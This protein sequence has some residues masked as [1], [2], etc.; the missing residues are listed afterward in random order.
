[1]FKRDRT[2]KEWREPGQKGR[3]AMAIQFP[4][5]QKAQRGNMNGQKRATWSMAEESAERNLTWGGFHQRWCEGVPLTAKTEYGFPWDQENTKKT[6]GPGEGF[7]NFGG[8][9][10]HHQKTRQ[11]S[12]GHK[13][14]TAALPRIDW[15]EVAA[16]SVPIPRASCEI[17]PEAYDRG[18]RG[19]EHCITDPKKA[20]R[21]PGAIGRPGTGDLRGQFLL[22]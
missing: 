4:T 1:L 12:S 8:A 22:T 16:T 5:V 6:S 7:C 15:K 13:T 10:S 14:Q 9:Q 18:G 3:R 20:E 2:W 11:G 19:R 21:N 17:N